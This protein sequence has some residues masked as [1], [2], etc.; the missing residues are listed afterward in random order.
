MN[1]LCAHICGEITDEIN[2]QR[3]RRQRHEYANVS[4]SPFTTPVV[5]GQYLHFATINIAGL[6]QTLL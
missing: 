1:A 3:A 5:T 2:L 6:K 4:S